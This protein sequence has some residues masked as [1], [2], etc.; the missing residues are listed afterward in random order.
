MISLTWMLCGLEVLVF[1]RA[2]NPPDSLHASRAPFEGASWRLPLGAAGCVSHRR[3]AGSARETSWC[4][5]APT[6]PER[7]AQSD[8]WRPD[9]RAR[10]LI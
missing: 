10:W 5:S 7:E 6:M 9:A 3:G 2:A 8:C 4:G 1:Q